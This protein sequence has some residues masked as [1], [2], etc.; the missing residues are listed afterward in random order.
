MHARSRYNTHTHTE[1]G[2][3]R[4]LTAAWKRARSHARSSWAPALLHV[5]LRGLPSLHQG[6]LPLLHRLGL[7]PGPQLLHRSSSLQQL[8]QLGAG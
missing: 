8:L 3:G 6:P 5:Q 2:E 1:P 7:R 4:A